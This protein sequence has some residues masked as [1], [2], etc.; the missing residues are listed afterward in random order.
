MERLQVFVMGINSKYIH[1]SLAPWCLKA[2]VKNPAVLVAVGEGT[3]NENPSA[4]MERMIDARPQVLGFSTYIWNIR[5]IRQLLPGLRAALPDTVFLMGG[6]EVSYNTAEVLRENPEI[7]YILSGEGEEPF[8]LFTEA[9]ING[10]DPSGIPGLCSREFTAIPHIAEEEPDSPY[11]EEYLKALKGR[12]A[13]LET[14]RGCP[15]SCAFCLSG[16]CGRVRCFSLERAKEELVLLANSGTQTVK[17]VDRTFNA[18]PKRAAELV[19]FILDSYLK[20]IP[21][22]V[23]FHF[24]IAGDILTS[25]LIRLFGEAPKGLFQ[26]EIGLQSFHEVTLEAVARKTDLQKLQKNIRALLENDNVH[27]HIDLIAGLPR[28]GFSEF[29]ESFNRAF[30]LGPHMLQLGFLK[31]LHGSPLEEMEAGVFSSQPPYEVISTPWITGEELARL[32]LIEDAL[33]R[34]WNSGRFRRTVELTLKTAVSPFDLFLDFAEQTGRV[35]KVSLDAYTAI[36]YRYFSKILGDGPCRDVMLLDRLTTNS[37]GKLPPCLRQEP[38][39][40]LLLRLDED[41]ETKRKPG[42]KRAAA[43]LS[44]GDIL[45]VDYEEKDPVTGYY[46]YKRSGCNG[47]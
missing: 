8:R 2:A 4:V 42:I 17:L 23:C 33:E 13:Y 19:Q 38:M 16:R 27:T 37:S 12:I 20:E 34:L 25:E 6:P 31:L 28:E 46:P 14:S 10:D 15:F 22:G 36:T 5:F 3:V 39:G 47:Y 43:K 40:A 35:E 29:R 30:A 41:P 11:T 1:S 21:A 44:T 9:L 26:L 7:D 32:S 18:Q 45:W 24:E